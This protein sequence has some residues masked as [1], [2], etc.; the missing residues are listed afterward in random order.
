[1]THRHLADACLPSSVTWVR[2]GASLCL[3]IVLDREGGTPLHLT[4][5]G[6]VAGHLTLSERDWTLVTLEHRHRDGRHVLHAEEFGYSDRVLVECDH[7][8]VRGAP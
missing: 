1:M 3:A 7:I 2:E 5:R 8:E 6:N 4:C